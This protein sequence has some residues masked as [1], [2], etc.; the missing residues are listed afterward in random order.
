[1]AAQPVRIEGLAELQRAF[2]LVD[3]RLSRDLRSALESSAEPVRSD[4]QSLA[5]TQIRR[6][7]LPWSRMRTGVTRNSVYVVPVERGD[8]TR[9]GSR[10][11]PRFKNLMLERAM[12]P[13]LERNRDRVVDEID[14]TMVDLAKAW[15]RV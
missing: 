4:A 7:T 8:K 13:A 15:A 6:M 10:R 9:R 1:M 11:R 2:A 12:E 3:R 5:L 14:D